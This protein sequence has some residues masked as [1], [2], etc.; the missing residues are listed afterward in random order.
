MNEPLPPRFQH[1]SASKAILDKQ[2]LKSIRPS[3]KK[4]HSTKRMMGYTQRIVHWKW[5]IIPSRCFLIPPTLPS[6]KSAV[7]SSYSLQFPPFRNCSSTIITF[8]K[9]YWTPPK[10]KTSKYFWYRLQP[11]EIPEP[12]LRNANFIW[13]KRLGIS[14]TGSRRINQLLQIRSLQPTFT[15]HAI[16]SWHQ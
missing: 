6:V 5:K 8:L 16:H 2:N 11:P 4:N 12:M 14:A 10:Q 15:F 9:N 7:R 1:I 3:T 13:R